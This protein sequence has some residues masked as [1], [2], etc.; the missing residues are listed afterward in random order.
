MLK[1]QPCISHLHGFFFVPFQRWRTF[2][3]DYTK[4]KKVLKDAKENSKKAKNDIK[5]S[6]GTVLGEKS[7]LLTKTSLK[8]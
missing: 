3:L 4:L 8:K 6:N 1:D 2:Y 7:S 5:D